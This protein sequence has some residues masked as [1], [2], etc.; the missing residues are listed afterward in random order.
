MKQE[1]K[2]KEITDNQKKLITLMM[3]VIQEY[4]KSKSPS[5][6]EIEHALSAN[7]NIVQE[8]MGTVL[9]DIITQQNEQISDAI[10]DA[11]GSPYRI[12]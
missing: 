1:E 8:L 9:A 4:Y 6:A 3:P 10:D 12:Y 2:K 11:D 5:K 7:I